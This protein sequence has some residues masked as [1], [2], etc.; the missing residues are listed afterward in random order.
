[1]IRI[2][3]ITPDTN[4]QVLLGEI[5]KTALPVIEYQTAK[6]GT[7][8]FTKA[9][10]L[11]PDICFLDSYLHDIELVELCR[12]F[13]NNSEFSKMS[14]IILGA[15]NINALGANVVQD[16]GADL[17]IM[18]PFKESDVLSAVNTVMKLN[19]T[20]DLNKQGVQSL[21]YIVDERTRLLQKKLAE[22]EEADQ[23]L[24]KSYHDLEKTKLATLNLMEDLKVEV[25]QRKKSEN[26]L[27]ENQK[28]LMDLSIMFRS[29]SDNMVDML[30][31]KDLHN[32]YI[33]ANKSVCDNL[34]I[35]K[36][37]DEPVGKNDLF[38][39]HR[40]QN[41]HPETPAWHTFGQ[42][43]IDSDQVI[44]NNRKPAQFDEFGN[45]NGKF[46]YLDVRKSPL[47]DQNGVLIGTVGSAQDITNEREM[48]KQ[49]SQSERQLSTLVSNLPGMVYRCLNNR[50][51]T[52]MFVSD[53][54]LNLTGYR[55]EDLVDNQT[56]TFNDIIL[57]EY[58][59]YLWTTWQEVLAK[60]ETFESEYLIKTA[61]GEIKWVWERG[62][63]I[64][65]DSGE[66]EY[67]EG[68]IEDISARKR[69]EEEL[70]KLNS[71]LEL[72]V[73]ERTAQLEASNQ[74]L[75][76]SNKELEAF[77]YSVSHD[78][79]APLRAIDG[80][81]RI[82]LE[83]YLPLLD[84]EGRRVC[85]VIK[86]NAVRMSQLIDDLL[87]L[88]RL[89]R[90]NMNYV[91]VNMDEL[92]RT[93]FEEMII[94]DKQSKIHFVVSDVKPTLG[95]PVLIKQVLVN[96]IDNAVKFSS[97]KNISEITFTSVSQADMIIY[98]I[99]DN[100]AGFDMQYVDKLFGAFQRLHSVKEFDGTGIGLAIVQ[101]IIHRHSGKVWATGEIG[102]GASFYFSIPLKLETK[103]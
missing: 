58:R 82:L 77:S 37:T 47:Y 103:S 26:T 1:M 34:L 18:K 25:D 14:L 15:E 102:Q 61:T 44:L 76:A 71:V 92:A 21:E 73:L 86:E 57:E 19:Y 40:Q 91:S 89:N 42:Q 74:N 83:D 35:A 85:G 12:R 39:A 62:R 17:F 3:Y 36:D 29:I 51:W 48:S 80:F 16:C 5:L 67:L 69:A 43:C 13:K 41:L 95:D 28:I 65:N 78:L 75:E 23:A 97:K 101:R 32:N 24:K 45:V 98:C 100:G 88:S 54:C 68:Y 72:R 60:H 46:L 7:E 20:E 33:F 6:T 10:N 96:L 50:E 9:E 99:T 81:T 66:L 70:K 64:F 27:K 87:A 38:F 63:G 56:I 30:W 55:K 8:G 90:T 31:A 22:V 4:T 52:M 2:I 11:I 93:V 94:P 53:G 84:E 59:D 49:L 79:R